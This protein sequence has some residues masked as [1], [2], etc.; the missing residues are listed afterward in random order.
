MKYLF[1]LFLF[2]PSCSTAGKCT[3]EC[4]KQNCID[5]CNDLH[6]DMDTYF[7]SPDRAICVCSPNLYHGKEIK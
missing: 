1:L 5:L 2:L 7:G 6:K 3:L 4:T